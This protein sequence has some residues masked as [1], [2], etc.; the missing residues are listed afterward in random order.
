MNCQASYTAIIALCFATVFSSTVSGQNTGAPPPSA[1]ECTAAVAS[2]TAGEHTGDWNRIA[3]CGEPGITAVVNAIA[4]LRNETDSLYLQRLATVAS[5]IKNPDLLGASQQIA[6][7]NS[8]TV[9][10]RLTAL[11][12]MAEQYHNALTL[13]T[14]CSWD[15]FVNGP[16][17]ELT[18]ITD[19]EYVQ[20]AAMP[21]DYVASI[22]NTASQ[23]A[24]N[25]QNP[26]VIIKFARDLRALLLNEVPETIA[27]ASIVVS[28]TC[29]NKFRVTNNGS[30]WADGSYQ[31]G[32]TTE[33]GAISVPSN[34]SIDVYTIKT[35]PLTLSFPGFSTPPTANGGL[36]CS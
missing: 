4:A 10:A 22:A 24:S 13:R 6:T 33:H 27:P 14:D 26:A 15:Q 19:V 29:G 18:W 5:Y 12:I 23:V 35:G 34:G 16:G 8:A 3:R 7:D 2:L 20:V 11:L 17:C 1:D 28:Y 9:P 36:S 31:V 21:S 30:I 25:T 32:G